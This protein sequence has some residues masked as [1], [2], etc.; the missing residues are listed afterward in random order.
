MLTI[1]PQHTSF[2][3]GAVLLVGAASHTTRS[4]TRGVSNTWETCLVA[5]SLVLLGTSPA[6][7]VPNKEG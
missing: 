5:L 3:F 2:S 7:V 1:H 4:V 6:G